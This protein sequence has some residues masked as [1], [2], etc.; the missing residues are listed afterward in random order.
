MGTKRI[1]RNQSQERED[2]LNKL[3]E[4]ETERKREEGEREWGERAH[5]AHKRMCLQ[6][7][8]QREACKVEQ[9][10]WCF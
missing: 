6:Q 7:A 1:Y 8:R 9:R 10:K 2:L 3:R 4:R 5:T